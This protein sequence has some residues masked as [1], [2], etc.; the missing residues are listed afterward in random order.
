MSLITTDRQTLETPR[1][2]IRIDT[3]EQYRHAFET[4]DDT[5]IKNH[6]GIITN[7]AL[8]VQKAKL[9]GGLSTHRTKVMFFHFI[10]KELNRVVG[11]F[12]FHNWYPV[13]RRSEIGYTM[14]AEEYKNK[15]YM[16]EAFSVIVDYGFN[17]LDL[18]RME[19]CIHPDNQPSRKVV[20]R[21]GFTIEGTMK[22]HYFHNDQ[23]GDSVLYALLKKDYQPAK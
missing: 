12:A 9:A 2:I 3:E 21:M 4:S 6:F 23:L 15:G 1:L 16:K 17:A 14:A 20:E 19:A 8:N 7:D 11:N 22:E 18:N 5:A 13:H 10:E